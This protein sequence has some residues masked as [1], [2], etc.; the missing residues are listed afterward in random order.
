MEKKWTAAQTAAMT[1]RDKT[2]L[3][4]AAAGSGK[5][6]TL[7]ER[8]IRSLTDP[9]HP[10]DI[11]KMLIVTFTRAAADELKSRI[12]SALSNAL[13]TAQEP[14][15]RHLSEQMVKL[16]SAKICTIDAFYLELL[17]ANFSVLGISSSFRIADPIECELLGRDVMDETI[18]Y[19]YENDDA[20]PAL[21]ECFSTVRGA[22]YLA[23][24]F[25]SLVDLC[26]SIPEGI[27]F[28][29]ISAKQTEADAERDF[30]SSRFGT[31]I[32][33]RALDLA[34][35]CLSFFEQACQYL[36]DDPTFA[37]AMLPSF[38]YDCSFCADLVKAL[39]APQ[40]TYSE[41][42]IL[43]DSFSPI[44]LGRVK[45]EE[46]T[47]MS[48]YFQKMRS[49]LHTKIRD[50]RKKSFSH[51]TDEIRR[52]MLDTAHITH[53]L[54]ALL[55]EYDRRM[56]E[57]K[58]KRNMLDFTDI[59]RYTMQLLIDES[60]NP[61]PIA[62][63]YA[64][65]FSSIY[66]DEYQ[67]V[68][69]VQDLIF[70]A[71]AKPNNRFMV[72]D[73]KQSIY[74]FRGAEPK[75]FAGYRERFPAHNSESAKHSNTATVFMSENFRCDE[76]V[77]RFT[78][79]V[80]SQIF[81][82]CSE[83]IDYKSEDDLVFSKNLPRED[84]ISPKVQ[85]SV[86]LSQSEFPS[87]A[88]AGEESISED[89]VLSGQML[90]AEYIAGEID[91][92]IRFEKK[93][94]GSP[95]CAGDIAVLFRSRTMS[96]PLI[97]ALQARSIQSSE[98]DAE[99]YFE[100]PD[101]LMLLCLLNTIDNPHRDVYLAG[102]LRSLL[103]DFSMED[104]IQI[105][106]ASDQSSSLYDA[107][108]NYKSE[109]NSLAERCRSFDDFLTDMREKSVSLSV[110]RLLKLLFESDLFVASGL[111]SAQ[112]S[113]G[114]GGNLLRMYE[115]ARS[116]ESGTYKG[117]YNFI[118]FIN[119]VIEEN[120]KMKLPPKGTSPNRVN[121]MTIHQS[122]G[123]EFP[124]CFVCGAGKRFNL[125]DSYASL[126][127][128]YPD[129]IAMKIADPTGFARINTPMRE[130]LAIN[131][132]NRMI[133]EEMRVLYVALTRARERLYVTASSGSTADSLMNTATMHARFCGRYTILGCRSYLDWVLIPFAD[134]NNLPNC[135][136]LC[137]L[138][139][140]E[141]QKAFSF[142][143]NEEQSIDSASLEIDTELR[144]YL[145][146]KYSFKYPYSELRKLPAKLSVSHLSPD[147]LDQENTSLDLFSSKKKSSIPDFFLSDQPQKASATE[148]GT[149]T[150]LFLQFCDFDRAKKY[151]I[152]EEIDR[153]IEKRFLPKN[154][155]ELIFADELEL[156]LKSDL[157]QR[158]QNAKKIFREQRFN[159]FLLPE[160]FTKNSEFQKKLNGERLAVQGV[161]DLI[162]I[163]EDGAPV[164][165]DYKTDRLS[166]QELTNPELISQKMNRLHGLQLSYY[167]HAA[168]L[169]FG[170]PC[171]KLF[172]Y[173]TQAGQSF[174]I[175]RQ[176]LVFDS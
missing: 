39:S 57:E 114:E 150:H 107:L 127:V 158:I 51:S 123:L 71:I 54:Y 146:E 56:K 61:T 29:E 55:S 110:D 3:V 84:Y 49:S 138:S 176:D 115:Y 94:D 100:N 90:E 75:V 98:S 112:S 136:E 9:E 62:R 119:T 35:Y 32:S 124:I 132:T 20:F 135:A 173:S 22:D 153:L 163:D 45:E 122:K 78:N 80:C 101:V 95:I 147:A 97:Q 4:S 141:V 41:I 154:I 142:D 143:E 11:S 40:T 89:E 144:D 64:E 129:G 77:I 169:L 104:L 47:E 44:R 140:D 157:M 53:R 63:R 31:I 175:G 164:L 52:A 96:A 69:G 21:A 130:A 36:S 48:I 2:L 33:S 14:I 17:R 59:R 73:I 8:I 152:Q 167:A 74:G 171:K 118:Q 134:S 10:E 165:Y 30:L 70:S 159:V 25:L 145:R 149:A 7:T 37:R 1:I 108:V 170:K 66:I 131:M 148:R 120:K 18:E 113:D 162:L 111:V 168:S 83:S 16:G 93:A 19:F 34:D 156:F 126:L 92:L 67:D 87:D 23:D 38:E 91:R 15:N 116:F 76:N 109:H 5:T 117:L 125:D 121:L 86:L 151:G 99:R 13:A 72:G 133:E 6:A 128:E 172:V 103:F 12:F 58:S 24:T 79:L 85:V 68:D 174:E 27:E 102:T 50:L 106:S 137:F 82:V 81:S 166:H 139:A 26:G 65:E 42:Q 155:A 28:F 161:I 60:G 43:L 46:K 88:Q 105:R 160:N